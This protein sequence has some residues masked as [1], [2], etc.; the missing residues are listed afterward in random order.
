MIP[1]VE[2]EI[3][4]KDVRFDL[5]DKE[6]EILAAHE[7]IITKR[8]ELGQAKAEFIRLLKELHKSNVW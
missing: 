8:F 6:L 1:E 3:N 2:N 5:S 7:L 4:L